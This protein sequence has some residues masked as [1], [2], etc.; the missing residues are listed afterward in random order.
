MG[1]LPLLFKKFKWNMSR[2][3]I[4]SNEIPILSQ[5][6]NNLNSNNMDEY[7]ENNESKLNITTS[8]SVSNLGIFR[9][10]M[11]ITNVEPKNQNENLEFLI[12]KKSDVS[13]ISDK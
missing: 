5:N 7:I 10:S 6:D 8:K 1:L 2:R 3:P 12:T 11:I 13:C 9:R 4:N